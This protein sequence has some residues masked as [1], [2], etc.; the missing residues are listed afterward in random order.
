MPTYRSSIS[1]SYDLADGAS[2]L[3][4]ESVRLF[5]GKRRWP[6]RSELLRLFLD[7]GGAAALEKAER[8]LLD[9]G[10]IERGDSTKGGHYLL[11]LAAVSLVPEGK[12]LTDLAIRLVE[13]M[14]ERF[15]DS[16]RW[17]SE[18]DSKELDQEFGE[19][20]GTMVR[21]LEIGVL[22][23]WPFPT[24][25]AH[26]P[27]CVQPRRL[28]RPDPEVWYRETEK[29]E[30]D[31]R[32]FLR[33]WIQQTTSSRSVV[34]AGR[35]DRQAGRERERPPAGAVLV[36]FDGIRFLLPDWVA[37][38]K[39]SVLITGETGAGKDYVAE[40]IHKQSERIGPRSVSVNCPAVAEN[41]FEREFFGHVRGAYSGATETRG[42]Y[43]DRADRGTLFLNEI[44]EIPVG[45]QAKLLSVVESG[46]FHPVGSGMLKT[47]DVRI[48]AATNRDA[49]E[50]V[51]QGTLRKDLYYR[52]AGT[53]LHVPPLYDRRKDIPALA[54]FFLE[55]TKGAR[56]KAFSSTAL[57]VLKWAPW[58]G[59]VRELKNAVERLAMACSGRI[60]PQ[61]I[62]D[63]LGNAAPVVQKTREEELLDHLREHGSRSAADLC[64]D[65]GCS[66]STMGRALGALLKDGKIHVDSSRKCRLYSAAEERD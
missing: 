43:F 23:N 35:E 14:A 51:A 65:F 53:R 59:N 11:R 61:A 55:H 38:G 7:R 25:G 12:D 24:T 26:W 13:Y 66:K 17:L 52:L 49:E 46:S 29:A 44:G 60:G 30:G 16:E 62:Y 20:T 50:M 64:G 42:G 1:G 63:L 9:L 19:N 18:A 54:S 31:A 32:T 10:L 34:V 37:R 28:W 6:P 58:E 4:R 39:G 27:Y 36:R 57:A 56:G 3:L 45:F 8:E 47:V 33:A 22:E 41:M 40:F 5:L 15:P 2:Y 21:L 48:I